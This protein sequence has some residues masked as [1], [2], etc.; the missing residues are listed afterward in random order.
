MFFFWFV[1]GSYDFPV[2]NGGGNIAHH[3]SANGA[4]VNRNNNG[5]DSLG[6]F[7]KTRMVVVQAGVNLFKRFAGYG[8]ASANGGGASGENSNVAGNHIRRSHADRSS[9]VISSPASDSLNGNG[10]AALREGGGGGGGGEGGGG[11]G[12]RRDHHHHHKNGRDRRLDQELERL[13]GKIVSFSAF[14]SKVISRP[15]II[16]AHVGSFSTYYR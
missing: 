12:G 3:D 4:D 16:L 9:G 7:A 15:D 13:N 5:L 1:S 11:G 8:V 14:K 6:H 10:R 2:E